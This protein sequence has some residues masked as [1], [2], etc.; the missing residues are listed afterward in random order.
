MNLRRNL[1][2]TAVAAL[3]VALGM[4]TAGTAQSDTFGSGANQFDIDFVDIG[5]AGNAGDTSGAPNPAGS[6]GYDFRM[7]TYEV[8]QDMI[9]KANTLGSLGITMD[10]RGANQPATS[11]SWNEAARFVNW[12]NLSGG[13][14]VAYKFTLQ[15][16]DTGYSA[17]ANLVLWEAGD[18]GYDEANPYRNSDA[19]Y[20]LPS[21][22]EWY[23]AA[24][25]DAGSSSYYHLPTASNTAPTAVAGG[26]VSGTAVYDQ[27]YGSGPADITF[28]GG[29]SPY[30]TMGQ[31]GNVYEWNES[32]SS[33]SPAADSVRVIRGGSW[34]SNSNSLGAWAA[35]ADW[36]TVEADLYGF[37]VAS[38]P[39]PT[40]ALLVLL[41]GGAWFVWKRRGVAL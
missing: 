25:Y 6:V 5:N 30:G 22:D 24:F 29:L 37:R 39:E 1:G 19:K 20:F 32:A 13:F 28:A 23:K 18:A 9:T 15:P 7:G 26:T 27:T 40:T 35:N 33:G 31:A 3:G 10:T 8:S 36:S 12:L 14:S 38:V 21:T 2:T 4:M 41:A 16:G 17:N 11:V 34:Y